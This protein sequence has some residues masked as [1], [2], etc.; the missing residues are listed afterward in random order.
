MIRA[1]AV[2]AAAVALLGAPAAGACDGAVRT[3]VLPEWARAGFSDPRPRIPHVIGRSGRIAAILFGYPLQS[4]P[5][6]HRSNKI[7]W[8]SR[9]AVRPLSDLRVVA[10][11]IGGGHRIGKPAAR[12]VAG[13]PGPSIVDLPAAGCWR[14]EL[15]WSGRRDSLDLAYR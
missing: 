3:G 8:V 13:G 9:R 4:P 14:L 5:S 10:Q 15:R 7:L 6:T 2:A 1:I 11:R 12:V